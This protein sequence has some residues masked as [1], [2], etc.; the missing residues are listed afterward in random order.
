MSKDEAVHIPH[1]QTIQTSGIS[2][3]STIEAGLL[4]YHKESLRPNENSKIN[5]KTQVNLLPKRIR[6]YEAIPE[7][8]I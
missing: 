5:T 2:F 4:I 8:L 1:E 6:K 7:L 3:E